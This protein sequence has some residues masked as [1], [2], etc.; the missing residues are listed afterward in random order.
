MIN[1]GDFL[2]RSAA[3]YDCTQSTITIAGYKIE[4]LTSAV[5]KPSESFTVEKGIGDQYYTAIRQK[6]VY[7]LDVTLLPVSETYEFLIRLKEHCDINNTYFDV[8]VVDNGT[9]I[10]NFDAH[11]MNIPSVSISENPEDKTFSF[12]MMKST[13]GSL[14]TVTGGNSYYSDLPLDNYGDF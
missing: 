1:I 4:S 2:K 12:S 3:S 6:E 8:T 10:G 14:L 13:D 7:M 5:L 11:F 9:F